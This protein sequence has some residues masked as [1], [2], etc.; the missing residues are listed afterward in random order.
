MQPFG[1]ISSSRGSSRTEDIHTKWVNRSE[2]LQTKMKVGK[3]VDGG[4]RKNQS[5][6]EPDEETGRKRREE[7]ERRGSECQLEQQVLAF[8]YVR[9][10]REICEVS[11][12]FGKRGKSEN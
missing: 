6:V 7:E 5:K 10:R 12:V 4:K 2:C 9:A 11:G 1:R 3:T 8:T